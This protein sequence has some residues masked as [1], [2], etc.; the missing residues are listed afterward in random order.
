MYEVIEFESSNILKEFINLPW[1]IWEGLDGKQYWPPPLRNQIK[2][3]LNINKHPF[4]QDAELYLFGVRKNN[5]LITRAALII[6]HNYIRFHKKRHAYFGFFESFDDEQACAEIFKSIKQKA[7][8]LNISKII[9]P[10]SPSMNYESGI[11]IEGFDRHSLAMT[12]HNPPYY[13]KLLKSVGFSKARDMYAYTY[14]PKDVISFPPVVE[15]IS[16]RLKE[17]GFKVRNISKKNFEQELFEIIEIG[18][19]ASSGHWGF[20]PVSQSEAK[21]L[22]K[23]VKLFYDPKLFLVVEKDQQIVS[24]L[25]ALPD[26]NELLLKIKNGKLFPFNWVYFFLYKLGLIR[27]KKLRL[28]ALANRPDMESAGLGALIYHEICQQYINS[29]YEGGDA[30]WVMEDNETINQIHQ[31]L[32]S[33]ITKTYRLYEMD[34]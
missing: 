7:S 2:Q 5:K 25:L 34:L 17:R 29:D 24:F 21:S 31:K 15:K 11:L 8:G 19:I 9:G 33:K 20:A 1:A 27:I 22:A 32:G 16:S 26:F 6:D 10:F 13:D 28:I 4:Y 3:I 30:A 14:P 18:N 12:A 23:E